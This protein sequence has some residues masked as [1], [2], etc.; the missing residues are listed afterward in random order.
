MIHRYW[1]CNKFERPLLQLSFSF[2]C[3]VVVAVV[4]QI[5]LRKIT[6]TKHK[7]KWMNRIRKTTRK[8]WRD[9]NHGKPPTNSWIDYSD[10]SVCDNLFTS[11]KGQLFPRNF[12]MEKLTAIN[13][14]LVTVFSL[15]N[16]IYLIEHR[17]KPNKTIMIQIKWKELCPL[18]FGWF[19]KR[20]W[21]TCCSRLL[22]ERVNV[23]KQQLLSKRSF[24][25]WWWLSILLSLSCFTMA[26]VLC[27]LIASSLASVFAQINV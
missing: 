3:V 6:T 8:F 14:T 21:Q 27:L 17:V 13:R 7:L 19:D 20:L 5:F 22:L 23:W 25:S 15:G 26:I 10:R 2:M 9:S 16:R 11:K 4:R 24:S 12:R 18:I 1:I